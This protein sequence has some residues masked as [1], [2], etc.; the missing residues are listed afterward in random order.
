MIIF[1]DKSSMQFN[2]EIPNVN[3]IAYNQLKALDNKDV[4]EEEKQNLKAEIIELDKLV[5]V[6]DD[7]LQSELSA[8]IR[9]NFPNIAFI[10]GKDGKLIDVNISENP[11]KPKTD[12]EILQERLLQLEVAEVN[13]KSKEIEQQILGGTI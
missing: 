5:Y 11:S 1:K 3:I 2:S 10:L 4:T 13:R 6:V 8:K 7:I 12:M 9:N